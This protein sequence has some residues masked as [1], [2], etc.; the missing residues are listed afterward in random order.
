MNIEVLCSNCYNKKEYASN[1]IKQK[2]IIVAN[3]RYLITYIRC[4]A[5]KKD[6]VLQIDDEETK[7]MLNKCKKIIKSKVKAKKKLKHF[8]DEKNKEL[9]N[10]QNELKQKRNGLA[11]YLY[12]CQ[13][14]DID[15][16]KQKNN[17]DCSFIIDAINKKDSIMNGGGINE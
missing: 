14:Y 4:D 9:Y 2:E 1:K 5:C 17:L 13:Y 8:S 11:I 7:K 15:C 6:M 3:K 16:K 12:G 10:L